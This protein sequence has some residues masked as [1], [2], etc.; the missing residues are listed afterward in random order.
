MC[1][2]SLRAT[3]T[4]IGQSMGIERLQE[5]F[6]AKIAQTVQSNIVNLIFQAKTL[7]QVKKTKILRIS[8]IN[9]ALEIQGSQ[10]LLG[11]SSKPLTLVSIGN[12]N[13]NEIL[14]YNDKMI[15]ID[16]SSKDSSVQYPIQTY[17]E[18]EWLFVAG[19]PIIKEEPSEETEEEETNNPQIN[20]QVMPESDLI[21]PSSKH[22]VNTEYQ[23]F[24]KLSCTRILSGKLEDRELQ[25]AY[26]ASREFIRNLIPN[27]VRFSLIQ[28]RDYP[29]NYDH[30][31]VAT[32]VAYSLVSNTQINDNI[33]YYL[34]DIIGIALSLLISNSIQPKDIAE[35]VDQRRIAADLLGLI[36]QKLNSYLNIPYPDVPPAIIQ[37]LLFVLTGN[38]S[39]YVKYGALAGLAEFGVECTIQVIIKQHLLPKILH[40]LS[41]VPFD[42]REIA[43]QFY[44]L[45]LNMCGNCLNSDSIQIMA[46]GRNG[47]NLHTEQYLE[48]DTI[49]REIMN[50]FGN[51]IVPFII[52][53]DFLD[54]I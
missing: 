54:F 17:F 45:L 29:Q 20:I 23:F 28:M 43:S 13:A 48:N 41:Q 10:P 3:I 9:N 40:E 4:T 51:D 34:N 18:C 32:Y 27:F 42:E 26:L 16:Q 50:N 2:I 44:D 49:Y 5:S 38:Y 15:N 30:L 35:F 14:V 21:I 1:D 8:D 12:I 37:Q 39:I 19:V 36:V 11:Y 46:T 47:M 53:D 25:Y 22:M 24:F 52:S 7:S 6:I 33:F 31:K